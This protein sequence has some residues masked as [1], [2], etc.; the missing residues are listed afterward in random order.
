MGNLFGDVHARSCESVSP[1]IYT[2][3]PLTVTWEGDVAWWCGLETGVSKR[4][5]AAAERTSGLV[6]MEF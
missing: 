2:G 4:L 5:S 3:G 1:S 6:M